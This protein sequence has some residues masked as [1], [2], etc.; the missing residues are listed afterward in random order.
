MANL[1]EK[2]IKQRLRLQMQSLESPSELPGDVFR[3][4]KEIGV[5]PMTDLALNLHSSSLGMTPSPNMDSKR[6]LSLDSS[7]GDSTPSPNHLDSTDSPVMLVRADSTPLS[8]ITNKPNRTKLGFSSMSSFNRVGSLKAPLRDTS[9]SNKE[10]MV[11]TS[12]SYFSRDCGKIAKS[13]SLPSKLC[14]GS[15]NKKVCLGSPDKK[16]GHGTSPFKIGGSGGH[17]TGTQGSSS[18]GGGARRRS[19]KRPMFTVIEEDANSRDSGYSSQNLDCSQDDVLSFKKIKG[20]DFPG[21]SLQQMLADCSPGKEDG[22]TA[23][24][25]SP[26][27]KKDSEENGEDGSDCGDGFSVMALATVEEEETASDTD[28]PRLLHSLSLL[29][30]RMILPS[31][32]EGKEAFTAPTP[33]ISSDLQLLSTASFRRPA[34]SARPQFRRALSMLEPSQLPSNRNSPLSRVQ[35][36]QGDI[37]LGFKRP[38]PPRDNHTHRDRDQGPKLLGVKKRRLGVTEPPCQGELERKKP[39]FS[40]SHSETELSIMRS[41]QLKEETPDILPDSSRL[42]A[43]PSLSAG[44][45]HPSLRSITCDT[46]AQVLEGEYSSTIRSCRVVDVRYKFE[47]EGGHIRGAENW[48]HGED[49]EFLAAFLPEHPLSKAPPAYDSAT[50]EES[51]SGLRDILVFHCEFSS[52]RGPDFYKKLRERDRQLNKDVYPALH[53]PECYLLHLGY[54]EFW[55]NYPSLC[56]GSYTEM[57]DPRHESDL[58]RMRAKSKSWSGG[59]V[60]RTSRLG[61]LNL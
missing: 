45:K 23:L 10:N 19:V 5:S 25:D 11:P 30:N 26:E 56:T 53:F 32:L 35:P 28:S 20:E 13:P 8:S 24:P 60:A 22:I 29:N 46:L 44:S 42:Y 4:N 12:N 58:R 48:Q 7:S 50:Y 27:T 47:Y 1:P 57:V 41:C 34:A 61:R 18:L 37:K 52:Q 40:R 9:P 54:K 31:E 39:V 55:R 2:I 49:T 6:R 3:H 38:E 16:T 15:P 36:N 51:S 17:V 33:D 59:T 14:L 43:L 21:E